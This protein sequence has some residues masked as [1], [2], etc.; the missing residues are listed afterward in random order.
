[1]SVDPGAGSPLERT[2]DRAYYL[3]DEIFARERERI[4]LP[5]PSRARSAPRPSWMSLRGCPEASCR[6]T[7]SAWNAGAGSSS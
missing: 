7:R 6:C 5:I 3:S 1:M 4:F 2:L